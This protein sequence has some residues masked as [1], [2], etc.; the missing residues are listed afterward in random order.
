[1][2]GHVRE[3]EAVR[4]SNVVCFANCPLDNVI[5]DGGRF[6]GSVI[7]SLVLK[8]RQLKS[9]LDEDVTNK[10][11]LKAIQCSRLS[12][13][14]S[15]V[16]FTENGVCHYWQLVNTHQ[17]LVITHGG[18]RY[19]TTPRGFT[20]KLRKTQPGGK[21][22]PPK[23]E[24]IVFFDNGLEGN[25][26]QRKVKRLEELRAVLSSARERR[27]VSRGQALELWRQSG[28]ERGNL[29]RVAMD[30]VMATKERK[31]VFWE[32]L[33]EEFLFLEDENGASCL[34]INK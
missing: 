23:A 11:A 17:M 24:E 25:G 30:G 10:P 3:A 29:P 34:L 2:I 15:G 18:F 13:I 12:A 28:F 22:E 26:R 32:Y 27:Y 16:F 7:P 20:F 14:G 33:G 19:Y 9:F 1:M 6:A 4:F 5:P 8:E 31:I 21:G